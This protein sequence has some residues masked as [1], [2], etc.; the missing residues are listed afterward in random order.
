MRVGILSLM[1][2]SNT[3]IQNETE[4]S[5]FEEDLLLEGEEIRSTMENAHHEIGGFFQGLRDQKVEAVPIFTAR[6]LPFGTI[7]SS[8]YT[9]LIEKMFFLTE[10]AGKLDG[11]LVAPHGATVSYE[12]PDADGHWLYK[13]RQRVGSGTPIIGTLDL[14]A[15]LSQQMVEATDALIGYRSNPHLDQRDRGVEAA[16]MMV[17]MLRGEINPCQKAVFPPFIMNIEKQCTTETPC[18]ELYEL[19]E[20]LRERDGILSISILQGFPYA[21]VSEMGSALL[22]I[23]DGDDGSAEKVLEELS[24]KL[25]NSRSQFDGAG[26]DLETAMESLKKITGRTCLLDMGDNVG[27]GSP[28]DGTLLAQALITHLVERSFVC[29]YDPHATELACRAGI[30]QSVVLQIGGKTD[31]NHGTPITAEVKVRGIYSGK[32]EEKQPRHGGFS[33]FDQGKTAVVENNS[34]LTVML[35]TKR[36]APFSLEQ[37]YSCD[38]DPEDFDVLVAKGVN[39]PLAAYQEVC[40]LFIRVDTP[41][42]TSANLDYFDY[43]FRRRPMYPFEKDFDWCYKT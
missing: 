22:A 37:L 8:A 16:E 13:L 21:D 38:L 39:S 29:L 28:A 36:M 32:F 15:N 10:K 42:V 35:T 7:S 14:H 17:K 6:A 26:V 20:K 9:K 1:Q 11:Y 5:H 30:G 4:L 31:S 33:C 41:G 40:S 27:G 18:K 43:Q 25:W 2:E 24:E 19:A 34:G 3:F 23:S 12:Y